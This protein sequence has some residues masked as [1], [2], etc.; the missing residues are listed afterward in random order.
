MAERRPPTEAERARARL[1]V[2]CRTGNA[3]AQTEA[4]RD[5]AALKIEAFIART[6]A[7]APPITAQQRERIFRAVLDSTT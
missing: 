5:L 6:L 1:G 2:A 4:R 7:G 3:A